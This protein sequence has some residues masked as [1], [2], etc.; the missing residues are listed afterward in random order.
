MILEEKDGQESNTSKSVITD[1]K[2]ITRNDGTRKN[3]IDTKNNNSNLNSNSVVISAASAKWTD[4]QIVNTLDNI[5]LTV[6]SGNLVA[7]IGPVGAG[8]VNIFLSRIKENINI[9]NYF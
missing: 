9:N 2:I 4:N 7:I 3:T 6:K 5:D 8:K 1:T